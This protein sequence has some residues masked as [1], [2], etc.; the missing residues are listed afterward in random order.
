MQRSHTLPNRIQI[1]RAITVGMLLIALLVSGCTSAKPKVYRVGILS[2]LD[3]FA[4]TTDSFKTKMSELGYIEGQNIV[5]DV[6][7]TN[8]DPSAEEQILNK[9]IADKVDLIF[10]FPTEVALAAKKATAGTNIPLLFA[11]SFIEQGGL[12]ESVRQPGGNITGVRFP[13]PDLAVKRLE[14]LHEMAPIAKRVWVP[15]QKGYPNIPPQL[16]AI[17]SVA[18]AIGVTLV[19]A[20]FTTTAELQADLQ[21][22]S[23]APDIGID[24]VLMLAEPLTLNPDTFVAIGQFATEHQLPVG[25]TLI[26]VGNHSSI[27]GVMV[28]NSAVGNQAA[29]L[30]DKILKGTPAGTIP[31]ATAET[32][33][34][35][36][37]KEAQQ[38]NLSVP[39]GLLRQAVEIIR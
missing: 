8:I 35:I 39:E 33:L 26:T 5:Y 34:K 16:E 14:I 2:G 37:Y 15:Y 1:R 9:F 29:P 7:K 32:F 31:L 11:H 10:V 19:E 25:G 18:A 36:N 4:N 28:D 30:A 22:R 21:A 6:Q 20:P 38:L 13:G 23:T 3:F 24:A 12:V 27:F 17:R